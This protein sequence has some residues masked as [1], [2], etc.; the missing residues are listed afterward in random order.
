MFSLSLITLN[1]NSLLKD[2]PNSCGELG[3][4]L[5]NHIRN[6]AAIFCF[7]DSR[8]DS[9]REYALNTE[10]SKGASFG[11]INMKTRV[12][13][14]I[15]KESISHS[16]HFAGITII[17]SEKL[18]AAFESVI[19]FPDNSFR[20]RFGISI[21]KLT[22]GP[23]IIIAA[24]YG[25]TSGPESHKA[26]LFNELNRRLKQLKT[27]YGVSLTILSGDFNQNL[28]SL[29]LNKK[30]ATDALNLILS[31]HCL[32]DSFRLCHPD[33]NSNPGYTF[34]GRPDQNPSRID[35]IFISQQIFQ[36]SH[37]ISCK[38]IQSHELHHKSDH[39]GLNLTL[40]WSLGGTPDEPKPPW[41]FKNHLLE[42]KSF[43]KS[44][45][46]R[47]RTTLLTEILRLS[48][49]PVLLNK[50]DFNEIATDNLD[51]TLIKLDKYRTHPDS[52]ILDPLD[53]IYSCFDC[54]RDLHIN[55]DK[56]TRSKENTIK[57]ALTCQLE[58]LSNIVKPCRKDKKLLLTIKNKLM[59]LTTESNHRK[60]ID[61][62]VNWA[63]LGET[64]STHFF[65]SAQAKRHEAWVRQL[66]IPSL[67]ELSKSKII[68]NST[69]IEDFFFHHYKDLNTRIDPFSLPNFNDFFPSDFLSKIPKFNSKFNKALDSPIS[70]E[71]LIN[72]TS[73]LNKRSCGGPD[74]ISSKLL[75]WF[76]EQCP[77]LILKAL[78]DQMCIGDTKD[79]PINDRNIIFIPKPSDRIDIKKY[80]PIS[81][82]NT[83]YRLCDI[84]LTQRIT[85]VIED[86]NIFSHNTY[87]Y[88]RS[89]SIPDAIITL[90][91]TIEN[92]KCSG[93]KTCIIQTDI[94]AGF[95]TVSR[96]HIKEVLK[97]I[98]CP[99]SLI[100]KIFNLGK[101]ARAK[102]AVNL[103]CLKN[104][105]FKIT[106]G[107][108]QG[109]A[110]SAILFNLAFF[111]FYL[112]LHH[113][114]ELFG[115]YKIILD[116][117]D[118]VTGKFS[119]SDIKTQLDLDT[120]ISY[121]DD[122]L[123]TVIYKDSTS[124]TN[125]LDLFKRFS[126]VS[127]LKISPA[128]SKIIPINF[129]F[130]ED[131]IVQLE[132]YGLNSDNFSDSF[133][134][135]GNTILPHD[136]L[137]GAKAKLQ[138]VKS[139]ITNI[140][141]SFERRAKR[142]TIRGRNLITNSLISS[143]LHHCTTAF[144]LN[145][146]DFSPIQ[147]IIDKF[148]HSKK[149]MK[150]NRRYLPHSRAGLSI[151]CLA[152]RHQGSRVALLKNILLLQ[153]E[154]RTLPGWALIMI[155]ALKLIG[156]TSLEVLLMSA[157]KADLMLAVKH[158]AGLGFDT[159]A[160]LLRNFL[161]VTKL[162]KNDGLP[163]T[164][165][166]KKNKGNNKPNNIPPTQPDNPNTIPRNDN[167]NALSRRQLHHA[168]YHNLPDPPADLDLTVHTPITSKGANWP[169]HGLIGSYLIPAHRTR[170]A[171]K[172]HSLINKPIDPKELSARNT[173]LT[174]WILT[175]NSRIINFIK[176]NNVCTSWDDF[177]LDKRCSTF[178]LKEQQFDLISNA[179]LQCAELIS[180]NITTPAQFNFTKSHLPSWLTNGF[181]KNTKVI[182]NQILISKY[183]K[184]PNSAIEKL[185]KAGITGEINN[186][187][188][189]LA[190]N[191]LKSACLT[192]HLSKVSTELILGCFYSQ[193][194]LSKIPGYGAPKPC[195]TC[196]IFESYTL[197]T[198]P[199]FHSFI[200]CPLATFLVQICEMYSVAIFGH[201]V[202]IDL[203][204]IILLEF[205][206][207]YMA[208]TLKS[209]RRI[210][211]TI[212]CIA[213]STLYSLYY[214]HSGRITESRVCK[215]FSSHLAKVRIILPT[216]LRDGFK[217]IQDIEFNPTILKS[218]NFFL[219]QEKHNIARIKREAHNISC[220]ESYKKQ[221]DKNLKAERDN[222]IL[223]RGLRLE[224]ELTVAARKLCS[225]QKIACI[226]ENMYIKSGIDLTYPK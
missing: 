186:K 138:L 193:N 194:R 109:Q 175:E 96:G 225:D 198:N 160:D 226:I 95:D 176:K 180:E 207:K 105:F 31:D 38:V 143:K 131:D 116:L 200:G 100:D 66:Q 103:E 163:E 150:G 140:I 154:N 32:V 11:R 167:Y 19:W 87:A 158:L 145:N 129:T 69:E 223:F 148:A 177:K 20:P 209:Q 83:L 147:K 113:K 216:S 211:Y 168:V 162:F 220:L 10:L 120:S 5:C 47:L 45:K 80:R 218:I 34:I 210:F 54:F 146:H 27:A 114:S 62:D 121:S 184:A 203:N 46:S 139:K 14:T 110:S 111:L 30:Q 99:E 86:S 117:I 118:H 126:S 92:I 97:L 135:L 93:I 156:F 202:I 196:S 48:H 50:N 191:R 72:A 74:G 127:G 71:E 119:D 182:T 8:V 15:N 2:L 213:K 219:K 1:A 89:F 206:R 125:I 55:H 152:S 36:N 188:I 24:I 53:L 215:M 224:K 26:S 130:S 3:N 173:S 104:R 153:R 94:E 133:T 214:N 201:R 39:L 136:L 49:S 197:E 205:P 157:G 6:N 190:A 12:F 58:A 29:T 98:G 78:N 25:K 106:S 159:L 90:C 85:R 128:K 44:M 33:C 52:S 84:C 195:Q 101:H 82:L 68:F 178:N 28:D 64:G 23:R 9:K 77:N 142:L 172:L 179:A 122:G 22:K 107:T 189:E 35:G 76:I 183:S 51:L 171:K 151:P 115:T 102:L 42:I 166:T 208:N 16:N 17:F 141:E 165:F 21:A 108:A 56:I 170:N 221:R 63:M 41:K 212:I 199:L 60:A 164:P 187:R 91:S 61:L 88:R 18:D 70:M 174:N 7:T 123:I 79:K 57:K 65:R 81:L 37:R 73:R 67:S 59:Q 149:I 4:S 132:L 169:N 217:H 75:E 124:I 137:S 155:K 161:S 13:T 222:W 40:N 204:G 181:S 144:P 112:F 192:T 43:L 185:Q 134:F